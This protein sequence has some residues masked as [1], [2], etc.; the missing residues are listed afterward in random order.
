LGV[1]FIRQASDI[2]FAALFFSKPPADHLANLPGPPVSADHRQSKEE[3]EEV[4][5]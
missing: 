4:K 2:I 3:N 1:F 5:V